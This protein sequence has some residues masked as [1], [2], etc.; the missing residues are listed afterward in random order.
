M[1]DDKH[2]EAP[3]E[4]PEASLMS[5]LLELRDRVLRAFLPRLGEGAKVIN[6]SSQLASSQWPYGGYYPYVAAKTGLNRMMRS[7]AIDLRD[8]GIVIGLIH[9]GYVQTDMGGPDAEITPQESAAAIRKLAA[10]WP[11]EKSGDFYKW[12]GEEHAW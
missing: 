4:L 2:A 9:P 7:V 6:F 12:N 1:A 11:L 3:E 10:W 5:H 8:R